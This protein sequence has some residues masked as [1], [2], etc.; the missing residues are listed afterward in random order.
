MGITALLVRVLVIVDVLTVII[1]FSHSETAQLSRTRDVSQITVVEK[2]MRDE[3][4]AFF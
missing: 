4:F 2:H 1:S 3:I